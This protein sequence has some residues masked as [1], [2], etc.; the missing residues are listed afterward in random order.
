MNFSQDIRKRLLR[1]F[2]CHAKREKIFFFKK[3]KAKVDIKW[4]FCTTSCSRSWLQTA[5]TS[6]F[7]NNAE[8]GKNGKAAQTSG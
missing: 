6:S 3:E 2:S 4:S 1:I 5:G 8:N 7:S